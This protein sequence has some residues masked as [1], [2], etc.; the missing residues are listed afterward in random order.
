VTD[1]VPYLAFDGECEGAFRFYAKAL[2]RASV[3]VERQFAP[4]FAAL[5]LPV[6]APT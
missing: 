3:V 6:E 2:I 5:R 4:A 1:F